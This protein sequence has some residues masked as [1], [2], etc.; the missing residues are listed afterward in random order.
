MVKVRQNNPKL[1]PERGL[2]GTML[3]NVLC[4]YFF[5]HHVIN[6]CKSARKAMRTSGPKQ[7]FLGLLFC[8]D[9]HYKWLMFIGLL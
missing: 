5:I 3:W 6:L 7:C 9:V 1:D 4:F 2:D 8:Q